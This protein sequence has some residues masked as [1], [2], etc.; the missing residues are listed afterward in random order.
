MD[1]LKQIYILNLFLTILSWVWPIILGAAIE[2]LCGPTN[3]SVWIFTLIGLYSLEGLYCRLFLK[4][5][6]STETLLKYT[7]MVISMEL[8][9]LIF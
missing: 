5:E 8:T 4:K 7:I 6:P 9:H 1:K 2:L 3:L